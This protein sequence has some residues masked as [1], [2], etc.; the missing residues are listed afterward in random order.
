M[1]EYGEVK[2]R[3]E[4]VEIRTSHDFPDPFPL[5]PYEVIH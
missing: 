3:F 2:V 4:D 1:S 5:Y